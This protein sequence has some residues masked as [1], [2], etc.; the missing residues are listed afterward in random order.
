[1]IL[2][3]VFYNFLIFP[4][5][6]ILSLSPPKRT[7]FGPV[8]QLS[9]GNSSALLLPAAYFLDPVC[10]F[11][12][13]LLPHFGE[14]VSSG[15]ILRKKSV[16]TFETLH[17]LSC[18]YFVLAPDLWFAKIEDSQKLFSLIIFRPNIASNIV[19][20]SLMSFCFPILLEAFKIFSL[21]LVFW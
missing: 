14:T 21:L 9:P 1:M 19:M 8:A 6:V 15:N 20:R 13:G 10:P 11:L 7:V 3:P 18:L 2:F 17:V 4:K 5:L 12:L 16:G